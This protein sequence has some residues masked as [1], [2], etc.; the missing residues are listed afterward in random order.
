[1]D[2]ME[3]KPASVF[4][5]FAEINKI[6]RPSKRE[7]K[8][9]EYLKDWGT[10]HHL[11]TRV[12]KTGNV[13][14]RKPATKGYENKPTVILQSHFDMVCDKLVDV[15]FDF[16]KD[17][18]Q[19]YVDGEWLK[20]KGTTLG[21]DDGIGV[22]IEL[23]ILEANDI[24]HGPLECVFTRDEETQLTGASGMEADFM[25]GDYLINLDSEDEGQVF[26]SCAGG[27]TTTASFDFIREEAPA[28]AF[29]LQ[30]SIKGLTGGHSGDDIE[31]KRANA[32]KILSR[33]LYKEMQK[34][35]IRLASFNS[36]R[37]HNAI[38]RD[39]SCVIAVPNE[40]KEDVRVDWN[41][42]A[43]EVENEFHVTDTNMV[44]NMNSC[45]ATLVLPKQVADNVVRA[46]Q[47]VDNG[48]FA[49][50]QDEMLGGMVETSSNVASVVT[51]DNTLTIVA[52]QRSNI[53]S[54]LENQCNTIK[55]AFELAGAAVTQNDGYPAWKMKVESHLRNIV[56]ETYQKLFG[57]AP[58]VRGIHA[59]L[60]CGL[61]SER[62]PNL[63]M[64]SFGPTL[65]YVHTPEER[66]HI[67]SVEKVWNHLLAILKEI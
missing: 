8:M 60:E 35:D 25:T 14:I 52:S 30:C 54:N 9:I 28:G 20:A 37:M 66:L 56:V 13:I 55:A 4:K 16:D 41:V 32:I 50:C 40:H 29:F 36:G 23:A 61:F 65:R 11:D 6:P 34:F 49:I 33:F 26:V 10:S 44:W 64:V 17:A 62:Y 19:T 45:D 21:A 51:A 57:E 59:G 22:A 7:E 1:M 48:V 42:F 2:K 3:L 12:D 18:I 46:L 38:P 39:G 47:A 53:M 63:D 24:E 15:E 43:S 58:I 67:P 5:H 31:K 27:K